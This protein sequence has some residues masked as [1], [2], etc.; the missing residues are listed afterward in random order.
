[1]VIRY[2]AYSVAHLLR[3]ARHSPCI[4]IPLA[5]LILLIVL[6]VGT[7]SLALLAILY[8]IRLAASPLL[9]RLN[10]VMEFLYP[11]IF[12]RWCHFLLLRIAKS[13]SPRTAT[14]KNCGQ[15]SRTIETRIEVS[16]GRVYIHPLPQ[17]LDNLG[18]LVV[19]C[20]SP[21]KEA[22]LNPSPLSS[23]IA[24]NCAAA[25]N[26]ETRPR[27]LALIVDCGD[28]TSVCRLVDEIST[29]HYGS[30]KI[31][32]QAILTTHKHHD[33]SAGN[34]GLINN[35]KHGTSI[36]LVVGGA[37]ERV[38]CCNHPVADGDLVP[39]PRDGSN[40]MEEL[41]RIEVIAA[42]AHTRG[43]VC[44]LMHPV[45]S[46][47]LDDPSVYLFTGDSLF[48]G[49]AGVPFE[50]DLAVVTDTKHKSLTSAKALRPKAAIRSTEG[51][52]SELIFRS[53]IV[54]TEEPRG[55]SNI[56]ILPGR[57]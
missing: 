48:S 17:L 29:I 3:E 2:E 55:L 22:L 41:I 21:L 23:I 4:M 51:C 38:P 9:H 32:I 34:S 8:F 53:E 19:C 6:S 7:L 47:Q 43:S 24:G 57:S 18:Y 25:T 1:M 45:T 36:K 52:I 16:E 12:G 27:I 49:G 15:H 31:E 28:A 33:H 54:E 10:Y 56:V 5:S 26:A 14:D 11:T 39:L 13:L 46:G 44:Y 20:P 37:V 42:P 35:E 30:A 40:I 50:S